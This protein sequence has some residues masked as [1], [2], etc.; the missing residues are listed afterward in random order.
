MEYL[1]DLRL[2]RVPAGAID[3]DDLIELEKWQ[4]PAVVGLT[5]SIGPA[6]EPGVGEEPNPPAQ[7][8]VPLP[9]EVC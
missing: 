7:T 3:E 8:P 2:G 5:V 4:V 9:V 1:E 6:L